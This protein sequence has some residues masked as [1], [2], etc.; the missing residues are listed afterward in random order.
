MVNNRVMTQECAPGTM[1]VQSKCSCDNIPQGGN[2]NG[3]MP[4]SNPRLESSMG[5]STM[6]ILNLR[7]FIGEV[8]RPLHS[9]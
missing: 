8:I 9:V 5:G 4:G 3:P 2:G 1:F 7:I 6:I